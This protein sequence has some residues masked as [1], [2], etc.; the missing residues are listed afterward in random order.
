MSSKLAGGL[1]AAAV[2]FLAGSPA[3]YSADMSL[4][5]TRVY[6]S[7]AGLGTKSTLGFWGE[8]FPYGYNWSLARACRRRVEVE[9]PHGVRL[10]TVW[11]CNARY[12]RY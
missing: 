1:L 12:A 5:T 7:S 11:V 10:R 8:A 4:T 3:A 9:T 2:L 6:S